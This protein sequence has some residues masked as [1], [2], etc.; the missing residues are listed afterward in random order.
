MIKR[1]L[2]FLLSV[3]LASFLILVFAA[4]IGFA[5]FI[6]NDF[7]RVSAKALIYSKWWFELILFILLI[8]L[9]YNL[10][11]YNL[12]R[13]EKLAVL[14]F[15]LAFIIILIG[16]AITRYHSFEGMMHIRE[17]E[18]SNI[19][20]SDDT[21]LQV[22]VD[23]R[24]L[25]LDYDKKLF[26]SAISN[27]DFSL[28]VKFLDNQISIDYVDFL[29]NVRDTFIV[30]GNGV[31]TLHLIVP[32]DNGMQ[33]EYLK[34][35]EQK[36]IKNH[37][38][39]FNN[40]IIGAINILSKDS[41]LMCESPFDIGS[42]KMID[43]STANFIPNT[44]FLL[45]KKTLYSVNELN[46]VLK[47][48]ISNGKDELYSSSKIMKD[49]STDALIVNVN[50]N[51]ESK[52][53]TLFGGKGFTS[54]PQEVLVGD[55]YFNL[56]YGSKNYYT[57]FR[58]KL[59]DFQLER[60]PG[61]MSPA[62]FAAEVTVKDGQLEKDFRIF[63]NN[64]LDYKGYRFFQSS[65]DQDEKGT[66]LSVNHDMLGTIVS[67]LGYFLLALGMIMV[68]FTSETRFSFLTKQ[69]NKLKNRIV[70]LLILCI[71]YSS[72]SAQDN[73]DSIIVA[74]TIDIDHVKVFESLLVQ[75]NGGRIKPVNTLCSEFLRKISRKDNIFN[76]NPSQVILGM[77][78]NPKLWSNVPMIK[79][80]HEKLKLLLETEEDRVSF[81][82]FFN[83]DGDYILKNL[84]ENVNTKA[85]INRDKY[86]KDILTVDE[87]INIC[88]TVYNG[89]I[90]RFFPLVNDS[91]NTWY[92]ARENSFFSNKDSLF[93]SNIMIMYMNSLDRAIVEDS[94]ATCD[95]VVSYI[96]KFQ[97]RYGNQV[98]PREYKVKLEIL[99]NKLSIFSNLFMYFFIVGF[100]FLILLIIRIFNS[101]MLSG[102]IKLFQLLIIFGFIYQTLGLTSRWIIS[103]HA[104][105]SNGYE[106]MIY[107]SW[108][109]ML[110]GII[111]S[112][113]SKM[114]L[115]AT[116]LV[117]SLFLMVA[118]LNWLDPEI[119]NIVP[120]LNSY[121]LMIHVSIITASYGFLSLGA[122][123]GL[124]SLWLIIF[125]NENTKERLVATIK[126]LTLINEK[127][128]TIGLF[129]LAIGTFLGGVWANESWGRYWGWDPK[130]TWALV[131]VLVYMFILHM[132]LIPALSGIYTFNLAS[133]IGIWSI[134]MTYFGVN[135]YLS[136][137][138]SYAAGDPMPIPSFVY[139]FIFITL[140]TAILAK[141]KYKRYYS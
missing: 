80:T 116:T 109:T 85:P 130:E 84:V 106:S 91:N 36:K 108:A 48:I 78:K 99:Y 13:K 102:V 26:L 12:F 21:F 114:T 107:I 73:L 125:S 115:A 31:R 67:Y 29:P 140:I 42:M 40:P 7:G 9:I 87:R 14:T 121:W 141:F 66:I 47:E 37:I 105:W 2:G 82:S 118:H 138:H 120:V 46:F 94:W 133:L 20:V 58:I 104:P 59:R 88:F 50:C 117:T 136:G 81:R 79:I 65:Y 110:S 75:D 28:P 127:S 97:Y 98:I 132:R 63:M 53:L 68:F 90:F 112:K 139:Y 43:R 27:N 41:L 126:E 64:V 54:K 10:K 122:V 25:Q 4:V 38:F 15:H 111:F 71:S 89:D 100:V 92:T 129:M 17:G 62:S 5:T 113:K 95:S 33:S 69:L 134:I 76:Q 11:R 39:T 119:T 123:L 32:G 49:G 51:G 44:S 128:I 45:S 6:E 19:I 96:S 30:G 101:N 103:G 22:R 1:F 23:N 52:E 70:L 24:K 74:N 3:K 18:E 57:P 135:Y 72:S 83:Q 124:F 93:V 86:D 137:L 35:G 34:D 60:Y 16:S 61:S 56:S 131:S 77:M 55:V 8:N